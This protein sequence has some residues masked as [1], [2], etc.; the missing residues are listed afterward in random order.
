MRVLWR[1][2]LRR[3]RLVSVVT[4][5]ALTGVEKFLREKIPEKYHHSGQDT[6]QFATITIESSRIVVP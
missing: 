6:C 3:G 5:A 2:R 4:L 1:V